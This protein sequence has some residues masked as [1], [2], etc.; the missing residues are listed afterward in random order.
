MYEDTSKY[1]PEEA[2][3]IETMPMVDAEVVL[4]AGRTALDVAVPAAAG[5]ACLV[6]LGSFWLAV[7]VPPVLFLAQPALRARFGRGRLPHLVWS[8]GLL[9]ARGLP[10]VFSM[11]RRRVELGP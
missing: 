5:V 6:V 1:A 11:R 8:Y 10:E 9:R 4:F 7:L 2:P 3:R